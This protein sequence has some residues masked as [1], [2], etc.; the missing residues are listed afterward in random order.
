DFFST[1]AL[2]H[3][4]SDGQHPCPAELEHE[5][6]VRCLTSAIDWAPARIDQEL[7]RREHRFRRELELARA[8]L[9]ISETQR[10]YLARVPLLTL[11]LP[12]PVLPAPRPSPPRIPSS[13]LRIVSWGGLDPG[14]GMETLIRAADSLPHAERVSVDHFGRVLDP[15]FGR[16]LDRLATRI[17]WR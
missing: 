6:C 17:R 11:P 12:Y 1:C 4:L 5:A 3:R 16:T 14:K 13:G 8:R 10:E 15:E 2:C 7:R 9:A